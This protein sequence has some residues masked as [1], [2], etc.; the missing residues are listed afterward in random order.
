MVPARHAFKQK[1]EKSEVDNPAD[2]P[3]NCTIENPYHLVT[4]Y[5]APSAFGTQLGLLMLKTTL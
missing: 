1:F 5:V 2:P 3:G 4:L